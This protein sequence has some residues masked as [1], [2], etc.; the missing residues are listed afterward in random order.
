VGPY[1]FQE[2]YPLP[3]FDGNY[4]VLGSWIVNGYACGM[5]VREDVQP[6]TQ[7]TSRFVPHRME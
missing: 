1:V 4:A 6:I 3:Q 5:G 2:Y 7:N